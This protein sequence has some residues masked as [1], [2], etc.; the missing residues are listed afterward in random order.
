MDAKEKPVEIPKIDRVIL[1][2]SFGDM[3]LKMRFNNSHNLSK[4]KKGPESGTSS[5]VRKY[6]AS[7][8]VF[9]FKRLNAASYDISASSL[10][11]A[12]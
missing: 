6:A 2:H 4:M 11:I 12:S 8:F 5:S 1:L 10:R 3:F 9:V 7:A